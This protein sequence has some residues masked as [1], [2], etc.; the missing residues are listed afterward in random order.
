MKKTYISP[1]LIVVEC[2]IE[3]MLASSPNINI[4]NDAEE[5]AANT[6]GIGSEPWGRGTSIWDDEE[7]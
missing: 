4:V 3:N 1:V 6:L 7:E 5:D 2:E